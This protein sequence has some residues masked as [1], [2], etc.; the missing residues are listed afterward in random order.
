[1]SIYALCN[2]LLEQ[3]LDVV[4][5]ADVARLQQI[6]NFCSAFIF[7]GTA[8]PSGH[9]KNLQCGASILHH[10]VTSSLYHYTPNCKSFSVTE[11]QTKQPKLSR[12]SFA[13][14]IQKAAEKIAYN[15]VRKRKE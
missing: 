2:G 11:C 6:T 7:F 14:M 15:K 10:I 3:V 8:I 9:S 5:A 12:G 1:V 4:H 13:A